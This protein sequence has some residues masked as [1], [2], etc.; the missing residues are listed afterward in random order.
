MFTFQQYLKRPA[1]FRDRKDASIQLG[2]ALEKYKNKNALVLGIPRGGAETAY[3]VAKHLKAEMALVVTR[4]LGHPENPE[5]AIGALAEDGSLY[6]SP[7][8][9]IYLSKETIEDLKKDQE[10]EIQRRI[11]EFRHGNPLPALKN[12]TVIIVDDG[13]ATGATLFATI[14]LCKNKKAG[15]IVVAAPVSG[16]GMSRKLNEMVDD[17]VILE[18][19][20]QYRAVSQAYQNFFNLTDEEA[21]FF[22]EK[23]KKENPQSPK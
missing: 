11:Q 6:L 12:R 5:Y 16:E 9:N 1:M 21:M 14:M 22:M 20:Y 2:E 4:K 17:V 23:W 3:Y 19:P 15:K 8:A 7:E 13:I 10:K 18:T